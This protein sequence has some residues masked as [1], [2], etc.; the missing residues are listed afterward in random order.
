LLED[1]SDDE[2]LGSYIKKKGLRGVMK[3]DSRASAK[4]VP[5]IQVPYDYQQDIADSEW[6]FSDYGSGEGKIPFLKI[7]T[8]GLA[9]FQRITTKETRL[10]SEE[11]VQVLPSETQPGTFMHYLYVQLLY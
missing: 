9:G 10:S 7:G 5:E 4:K 6:V 2:C 3:S 1:L 11:S 8:G